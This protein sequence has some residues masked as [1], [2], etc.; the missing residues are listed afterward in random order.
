MLPAVIADACYGVLMRDGR[1]ALASADAGEISPAF[2]RVVEAVVLMSGLA[3][4]NGGL[5][6]AHSMT[7]G[8]MALKGAGQ[9]LHGFHVAYGALVQ[10]VH[11][12]DGS[13]YRDLR[14]YLRS[15]GLP[16]SLGDLGVTVSGRTID[17]LVGATVAAPHMR[18][19]VPVP[20][21]DSL[22]RAIQSVEADAGATCGYLHGLGEL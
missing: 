2:E 18:N 15:I 12:Q 20:T 19:C 13:T 6:L 10:L 21:A 4:E 11:E 3:F 8:L 17:A 16:T 7:R 14:A 22:T 5:S 1:E 9:H